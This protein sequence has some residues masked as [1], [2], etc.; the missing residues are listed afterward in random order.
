M[1]VQFQ[2]PHKWNPYWRVH[3]D[4]MV[5]FQAGDDPKCGKW[6][7]LYFTKKQLEEFKKKI[8]EGG[9]NE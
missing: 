6:V 1:E 7:S 2:K 5:G 3:V 4:G 8:K 9:E